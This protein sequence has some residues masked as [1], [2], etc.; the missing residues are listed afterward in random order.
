MTIRM[1]IQPR[2]R[3]EMTIERERQKI[4][5]EMTIER[6]RQKIR[7]EM[8]IKTGIRKQTE[9]AKRKDSSCSVCS[10]VPLVEPHHPPLFFVPELHRRRPQ[11]AAEIQDGGLLEERVLFVAPLQFVIRNLRAEVVDVMESDVAT[12][13]L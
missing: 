7:S 8:T 1:N 10:T 4:R 12:E 9:R 11:T 6:G 13:P 2:R 3:K 5:N